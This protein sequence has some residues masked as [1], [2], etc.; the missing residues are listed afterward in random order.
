MIAIPVK[1]GSLG[2]F[3][4]AGGAVESEYRLMRSSVAP[5]ASVILDVSSERGDRARQRIAEA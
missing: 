4:G 5:V 3:E 2:V 1:L